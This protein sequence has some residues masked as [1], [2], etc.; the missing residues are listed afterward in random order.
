MTHHLI[1]RYRHSAYNI[2][3]SCL[4]YR[5]AVILSICFVF[6]GSSQ[7][8]VSY[9]LFAYLAALIGIASILTERHSHDKRKLLNIPFLAGG[10]VFL[11]FLLYLVPLPISWTQNMPFRHVVVNSYNLIDS[12]LPSFLSLSMTPETTYISLLDFL[13][14][15]SIALITLLSSRTREISI[16]LRTIMLLIV[17]AAFV[18]LLQVLLNNPIF[19]PYEITNFG[20]PVGFFANTN[21]L[22]T[23][24]VLGI[25]LSLQRIHKIN[26]TSF[27]NE[28]STMVWYF[29]VLIQLIVL[30]L[31]ESI[32]AVIIL[33]I[34]LV[35]VLGLFLLPR[36]KN[37]WQRLLFFSV[38]LLAI[39]FYV[40]D[41]LY[42]GN[43]VGSL[44]AKFN[45]TE[46]LS[47]TEIWATLLK[48][49]EFLSVFGTGPGSFYE[50]YLLMS[51]SSDFT[52]RYVPHA[53]NDYLEFYLE[54]GILGIV[55]IGLFIFWFLLQILK[56]FKDKTS[57][58]VDTAYLKLAIVVPLLHSIA[59]YPLR[60]I[61][62]M[63]IF[64]FFT[65]LQVRVNQS[66]T[67]N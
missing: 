61:A 51:N 17:F 39:S 23:V 45:N 33:L 56:E 54:L 29:C 28:G 34:M 22:A 38:C 67:I 44:M 60:T 5:L 27:D 6:G 40:I 37:I 13:P 24:L 7:Y 48:S 36:V 4:D 58:N 57:L 46:N 30:S 53:H 43:N 42:L 35:I 25:L 66:S 32:A 9:K 21:H 62:V 31:T 59:D 47:R 12:G 50:V 2:W 26:Q 52:N 8:A 15:F 1:Q 63:S 65:M 16:T 20:Y 41:F 18:G 55:V 11:L 3:S 64:I 19:Y 49:R 14:P 10:G